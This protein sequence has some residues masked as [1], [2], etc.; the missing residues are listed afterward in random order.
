[1]AGGVCDGVVVA[2]YVLLDVGDAP[3]GDPDGSPPHPAS[4]ATTSKPVH[5]MAVTSRRCR[6]VATPLLGTSDH[7]EFSWIEA[8]GAIVRSAWSEPFDQAE[9]LRDRHGVIVDGERRIPEIA[10]HLGAVPE[11]FVP[12]PPGGDRPVALAL[13]DRMG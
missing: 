1:M 3:L 9:P 5:P 6:F 2:E 10:A 7:R 4:P 13:V 12:S 11:L 8:H